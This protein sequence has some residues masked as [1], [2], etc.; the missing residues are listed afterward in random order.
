M[1]NEMLKYM[2]Y[3]M[4][5]VFVVIALAYYIIYNKM[6][7]KTTKYVASLVQGTRKSSFNMDVFSKILY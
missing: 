3:G 6:Q 5:G 1:S 2:I 7:S 4:I